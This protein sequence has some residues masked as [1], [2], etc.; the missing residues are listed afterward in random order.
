[1]S[2]LI[3]ETIRIIADL[4]EEDFQKWEANLL[5]KEGGELKW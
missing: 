1:M 4:Y 5:K 2:D 3:S